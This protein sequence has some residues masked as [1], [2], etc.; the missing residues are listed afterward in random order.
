VT[1]RAIDESMRL[2]P[3]AWAFTRTTVETDSF[4]DFDINEGSIVV[5]SPFVNHRMPEFW[6][7]PLRF[8]P[9]RFAEEQVRARPQL[10]YFP[11]GFGPH[12]CVGMHF[13]VIEMRIAIALMLSRFEVELVNGMRVREKPQIANTPGPVMVR[14]TRR[15]GK[16]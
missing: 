13:A 7:S 1:G 2:H 4:E 5:I 15:K 8:D 10:H 16:S 9:N 3:P 14:I 11:F 12:L 6:P